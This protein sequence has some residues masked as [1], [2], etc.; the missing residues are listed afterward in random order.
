MFWDSQEKKLNC[1]IHPREKERIFWHFFRT[2]IQNNSAFI[3]ACH[4][5]GPTDI[6]EQKA[7]TICDMSTNYKV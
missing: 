5:T 2:S 6:E 7:Q 4:A 3:N 1:Y